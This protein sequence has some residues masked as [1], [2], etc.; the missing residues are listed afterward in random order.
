[1]R[2]LSEAMH[3][4]S[5]SVEEERLCL[6]LTAM[7][8]GGCNQFLDLGHGERGEQVGKDWPKRAAQPDI[9]EVREVCVTD[10]VVVGR[11]SRYN[12][13]TSIVCD[14]SIRLIRRALF[15]R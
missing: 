4:L 1:M 6:L 13:I 12:T 8:V 7:S 11:I 3:R 10:V 5:H 14:G 15:H 9:E 2:L